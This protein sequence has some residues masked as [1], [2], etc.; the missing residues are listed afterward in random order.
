MSVRVRVTRLGSWELATVTSLKLTLFGR[1]G[2][3]EEIWFS[4]AW[5]ACR[6]FAER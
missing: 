5:I 3:M 1:E 2:E 4:A 6:R